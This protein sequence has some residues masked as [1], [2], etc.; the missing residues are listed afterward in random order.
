MGV[1]N[2][3]DQNP[4]LPQVLRRL[5]VLGTGEGGYSGL[6]AEESRSRLGSA[7]GGAPLLPV[8]GRLVGLTGLASHFR[9]H[10]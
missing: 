8:I 1:G 7:D 6:L 2:C 10:D 5:C 3:R 9:A 4:E